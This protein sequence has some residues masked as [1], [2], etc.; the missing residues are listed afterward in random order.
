MSRSAEINLELHPK[1]VRAFTSE[2]TEILYGGAAGGG[3]SHLKRVAA[4][5]W[6]AEIP[7]L[8]VYLFRRIKE[9]LEKNHVEGP[10]GFRVLLGPWV[11][12]GLVQIIE[13]EIRF[14]NGSKIWLCHC[15]DEKHR[16]KYLGAE[17]HVL[18][19]DEL[20]TF[21]EVIYRFLRSRVRAPGLV[22]PEKYQGMF[23]RI[24][25]GSN[26]GNVGHLWVKSSFVLMCR[27][28]QIHRM[29]DSEGGMFRQ[30]IP[31]KLD[32]N[33]SME[34]NDPDYRL[35]LRGMGSEA[36]VKAMEHGDWDVIEGAYFDCWHP[37]LII[38]PFQIPEHWVKFR[39]MD[40]GSAKPFSVGWYAVADGS[41]VEEGERTLTLPRGALVKYRE[42]YGAKRDESGQTVPDVGL[43]LTA[44]E[45]ADGIVQRSKEEYDY[46]VIDPAAFSEEGG[47][48]YASRLAKKGLHFH[49]ADNKR[50]AR[51]SVPGGWDM[52]RNRMKGDD[53]G[54]PMLYFFSTC[55]DSIRTIPALQHDELRPEDLNSQSE[56]HCFAAGTLVRTPMGDVPIEQLPSDGLVETLLGARPYYGA[57]LTRCQSEVV[58]LSFS[59]GSS[60][61]CTPDH[62][63]L[64]IEGKWLSARDFSGEVSYACI[65]H[66][67]DS[68]AW[69]SRLLAR[70]FRSFREIAT[71]VADRI[72]G[73][74]EGCSIG[75]FGRLIT[76]RSQM[77][78]MS[79]M[80]ITT[81]QTI[82]FGIYS[83]FMGAS[84]NRTTS[85]IASST[86]ERRSGSMRNLLLHSGM[87]PKLAGSG[88]N[89]STKNI[90]ERHSQGPSKWSASTVEFSTKEDRLPSRSSARMLANQR[91]G[92]RPVPTML[93]H[94]HAPSAAGSSWRT[95]IA[96]PKHVLERVARSS[97]VCVEV[98]PAGK[99]DV[100]CLTVPGPGSFLLANGATVSNCADETR[101]ACM[102]RPWVREAPQVEKPRFGTDMT[103]N[104][105][106]AMKRR[107]RLANG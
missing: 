30:Y 93:S 86:T 57:R 43:K 33:P 14:W 73:A 62:K 36:L 74:M 44:E 98:S 8:Q 66:H 25:C 64:N 48:S 99:A 88:T 31:A 12:A 84:I 91:R 34:Q 78:T 89:G 29:P 28:G 58:R 101:Y 94:P 68:G 11:E 32:D 39:A 15:K 45:V 107:K 80:S 79:T 92:A 61:V 56:D 50:V 6:C 65:S 23:P 22:V 13:D 63:L 46:G 9:D 100:Y 51:G 87:V 16:Y 1:Q 90:A 83:A 52:M 54:K 72:F 5:A 55:V 41:P 38:E 97:L 106:V 104:E 105:L 76:A 2:A 59:D 40:P 19:I 75:W 17:I 96:P 49:K 26:P 102:S 60:V 70:P 67:G 85:K 35:K 42:W 77:D 18:M 47:P 4:I 7:G 3:K 95:S 69:L 71:T 27:D 81:D 21:T 10:N 20:T 37:G 53:D 24:L 82:R 103:F